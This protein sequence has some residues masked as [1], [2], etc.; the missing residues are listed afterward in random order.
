[1]V[2]VV[3][4]KLI[5]QLFS[6]KHNA[7]NGREHLVADV[8]LDQGKHLVPALQFH[9]LPNRRDVSQ[10]KHF[11]LLVV[12]DHVPH[13]RRPNLAVLLPGRV[14]AFFDSNE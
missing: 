4:L 10:H 8:R 3:V 7:L 14:A 13:V 9:V 1:M 2:V 6:H 11:A 5:L 12:E